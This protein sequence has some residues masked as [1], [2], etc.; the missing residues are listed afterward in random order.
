MNAWASLSC[1]CITFWQVSIYSSA[2]CMQKA[3]SYTKKRHL[4]ESV[5]SEA[6]FPWSFLSVGALSCPGCQQ[7]T[8]SHSGAGKERD[9]M[10]QCWESQLRPFTNQGAIRAQS[11][12]DFVCALQLLRADTHRD[13]AFPSSV[14]LPSFSLVL[15]FNFNYYPRRNKYMEVGNS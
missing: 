2:A 13:R 12:D 5:P 14:P 15:F 3:L 10:M 6:F 8:S 9:V 7:L 1:L 4:L 11:R